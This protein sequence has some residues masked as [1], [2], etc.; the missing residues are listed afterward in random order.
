MQFSTPHN[1]PGAD[2][3]DPSDTDDAEDTIG[4]TTDSGDPSSSSPSCS[5]GGAEKLALPPPLLNARRLASPVTTGGDCERWEGDGAAAGPVSL[6][7]GE[8]E[9]SVFVGCGREGLLS[10][11]AVVASFGPSAESESGE[12]GRVVR[13]GGGVI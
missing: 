13:A 5:G 10:P 4:M 7:L 6:R 3:S 1:L 9:V 8:G 12:Q 11:T 2:L